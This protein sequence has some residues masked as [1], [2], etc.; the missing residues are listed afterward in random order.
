MRS[1]DRTLALLVVFLLI[2]SGCSGEKTN[3]VGAVTGAIGLKEAAPQPAE[4]VDIVVDGSAGSPASME[5][6]EATIRTVLPYAAARPGSEVRLWVLGVE[7][8]DTRILASVR[9]SAPKRRGERARLAEA[10]RF[11]DSSLPYLLQAVR[12]IFDNPA[13]KQS[14]IAEGISRVAFSHAPA[15]MRRV[16]ILVTDAREVGGRLKLDFECSKQLPTVEKFV[17]ALR[18]EAML[19]PG[20]LAATDVYFAFVSLGAIPKRGCAVTLARAQHIEALWRSACTAAGATRVEFST[21]VPQL[22][23]APSV[24]GAS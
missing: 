8:T 18:K 13:K 23:P 10:Q 9:S 7:I 17:A 20:S 19:S 6:V 5:S 22:E 1:K 12:P 11:T 15:G 3:I 2:L 16:V 21:D 14:P 24:G 4:L